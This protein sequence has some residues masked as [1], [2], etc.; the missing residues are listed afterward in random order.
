[1]T[2]FVVYQPLTP[3]QLNDAVAELTKGITEWFEKNPKRRIC[4]AELW[5]GKA[6]KIPRNKVAETLQK[7]ADETKTVPPRKAR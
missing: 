5:H 4:R 7:Y 1:M 2:M 3:K 6:A